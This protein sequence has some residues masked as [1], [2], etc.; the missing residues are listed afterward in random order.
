[1]MRIIAQFRESFQAFCTGK[2]DNHGKSKSTGKAK[3]DFGIDPDASEHFENAVDVVIKCGLKHKAARNPKP[4][5]G[6]L[7][8]PLRSDPTKNGRVAGKS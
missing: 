1:M 5:L 3:D 4:S 8:K 6:N 2:F 7:A